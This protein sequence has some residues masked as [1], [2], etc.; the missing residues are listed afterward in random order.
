MNF[1]VMVWPRRSALVTFAELADSIVDIISKNYSCKK[2]I[3]FA[4]EPQSVNIILG[5]NDSLFVPMEIPPNSII[6]NMEQLGDGQYWSNPRYIE[7]LKKF[8]IWD[9][10]QLNID[11]LISRGVSRID[12]IDIGYTQSLETCTAAD[13]QDIDVLFFGAMNS[14]RRNIEIRLREL[15]LKVTFVSNVFGQERD[16]LI[17]KSKIV[18]NIHYYD[19]KILE[20]VR[21]SHLLANKKCVI[22]ERGSEDE[23]NK[24]WS[25]GAILCD[26]SEIISNV[27]IYLFSDH[28]RRAQ[29]EAG[30][31]F[32]CKHPLALPINSIEEKG[33]E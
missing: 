21:L 16:I 33:L 25:Q 12:K 1:N 6:V 8:R 32:I 9:Y 4:E 26:Y 27:L 14:R 18:L 7:L 29:E 17:S 23:V 28:N 30:Y 10:S 11:Y 20:V 15:G 24:L 2:S 13:I 5:A 19:S 31:K 3:T 22:S